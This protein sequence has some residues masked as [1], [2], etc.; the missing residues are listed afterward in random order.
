MVEIRGISLPS[1]PTQGGVAFFC[2]EKASAGQ[3]AIPPYVLLS[4]PPSANK[5]AIGLGVGVTTVIPFTAPGI[6]AGFLRVHSFLGRNVTF[7]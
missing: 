2:Q 3:F 6:D 1:D 4:L 5:S 7:R